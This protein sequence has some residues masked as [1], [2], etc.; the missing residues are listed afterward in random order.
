M[1]KDVFKIDDSKPVRN[2]TVFI[3]TQN[4]SSGISWQPAGLHPFDSDVVPSGTYDKMGTW[5][6]YEDQAYNTGT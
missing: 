1:G 4:P 2:G 6:D 3:A 5:Y